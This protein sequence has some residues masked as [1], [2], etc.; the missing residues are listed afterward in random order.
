M[1]LFSTKKDTAK[2]S[3]A[4]PAAKAKAEVSTKDLYADEVK[5]ETAATKVAAASIAHRVL[6][7]PIISEKASHQS[8]LNQYFFAVANSTNKIEVARAVKQ[9]YGIAPIKVNMI[10]VEGKKRNYGRVAGKR[11]D[12]KKAVV[13]LP[14]G[15]TISL[16]EGV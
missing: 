1:A 6:L 8:G 9:V 11:K 10:R 13:T 2:K 7:R 16:Y 14:K 4:K 12:W 15:K 5:K 3:A